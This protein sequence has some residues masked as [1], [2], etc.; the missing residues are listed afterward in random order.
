MKY[1]KFAFKIISPRD[2]MGGGG[3]TIPDR[4]GD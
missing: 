3:F 2:S 4:T 1:I